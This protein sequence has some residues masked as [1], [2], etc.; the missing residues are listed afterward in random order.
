MR[1]S[2]EPFSRREAFCVINTDQLFSPIPAT[3][4]PKGER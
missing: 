4:S 1:S 3:L 2:R